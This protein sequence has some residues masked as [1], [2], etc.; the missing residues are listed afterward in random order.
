MGQ[1]K[2]IFGC[3]ADEFPI[4]IWYPSSLQEIKEFRLEKGGGAIRETANQLQRQTS[5]YGG[6]L[7]LINSVLSSLPTYMMSFLGEF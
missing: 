2:E 1:Y 5:L 4:T 3:K 6:C 7:T